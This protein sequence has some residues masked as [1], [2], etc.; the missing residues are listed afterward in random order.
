MAN[1][2]SVH[3]AI[4]NAIKEYSQAESK[5]EEAN[6]ILDEINIPKW[7]SEGNKIPLHLRIE[8]HRE[9]IEDHLLML[10][11]RLDKYRR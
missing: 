10:R 1:K 8:K 3:A 7:D 5:V 4:G 6:S 11:G 9:Q 2:K